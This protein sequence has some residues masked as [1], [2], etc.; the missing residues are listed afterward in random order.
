[1]KVKN[2]VS[3]NG[4][5][6]PN[7]F[8]IKNGDTVWFQSYETIV[9]RVSGSDVTLDTN[10]FDYSRT[11]SKYLYL[12]LDEYAPKYKGCKKAELKKAKNIAYV[13]LN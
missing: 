13:D 3:A 1:M 4:N 2:M 12:F 6:V 10:A 8:I 9:A 5:F 7:Q 11:T